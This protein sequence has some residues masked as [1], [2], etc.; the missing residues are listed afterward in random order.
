MRRSATFSAVFHVLIVLLAFF[1]LPSLFTS[2][3]PLE[4][5]IPV[6]VYAVKDE[7]VLPPP[8]IEAEP[9]IEPLEEPAPMPPEPEV[10]ENFTPPPSDAVPA[11]PAPPEPEPEV[12]KSPEPA[13]P[14]PAPVLTVPVV[15]EIPPPPPPKPV[16][17]VKA[18]L[19]P[20]PKPEAKPEP[21]PDLFASLLASVEDAAQDAPD[22][23]VATPEAKAAET[24]VPQTVVPKLSDQP[25]SLS[26]LDAIRRQVSDNWSL[27]AGAAE[28]A[29]LEV[30]ITI[31]LM[32][33]GVVHK[34]TIVDSARLNLP[35]EEFFRSMAESALRAVQRAS[36]LQN[37]P[38]EKYAQWREITFTFRPP[39]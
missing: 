6:E 10:A 38:P 31:V 21:Q 17:V 29:D 4:Q 27:P 15:S 11:P 16:Q 39:V 22:L 20:E 18:E 30:E 9:E 26:V 19:A 7:T 32:P 1:G 2:D 5:P 3:E 37:L 12:V 8:E 14:P 35:G 23:E 24:T 33:D 28:A 34:A 13:P 36:P 25:L